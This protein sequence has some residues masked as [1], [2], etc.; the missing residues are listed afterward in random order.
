MLN[1]N[2]LIKFVRSDNKRNDVKVKIRKLE[3]KSTED[4]N[5]F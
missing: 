1:H 5:M 3:E 4:L 2:N